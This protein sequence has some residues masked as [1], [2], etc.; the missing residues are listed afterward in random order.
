VNNNEGFTLAE[1]II[2]MAIMAVLSTILITGNRSSND[3]IALSTGQATVAGVL[4]QAKS[5]TLA[6]WD[7]NQ[8]PTQSACGFGVHFNLSDNS[9]ILFQDLPT[10]SGGTLCNDPN[11][12][13]SYVAGQGEEIQTLNLNGR[14]EFAS[15]APDIV[16][17]APYL[18]TV[19]AGSVFLRIKGAVQTVE[20]NVTSGGSVTYL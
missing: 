6:K 9:L 20:I 12:D 18:K 4:N 5:M 1:T 19:G 8:D 14:I 10:I 16:F 13:Y 15:P 2:V 3:Q 7:K 11:H 17:I